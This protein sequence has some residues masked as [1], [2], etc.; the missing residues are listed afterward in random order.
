MN[1]KTNGG[2]RL[3]RSWVILLLALLA[4]LFVS[5]NDVRADIIVDDFSANQNISATA[6]P[7]GS[8]PPQFG[9]VQDAGILGGE[10]DSQITSL[11]GPAGGIAQIL[12]TGGLA[13]LSLPTSTSGVFDFLYDGVDPAG[14]L[15]PVSLLA[16]S[17]FVLGATSDPNSPV[18]ITVTVFDGINTGSF[19]QALPAA[20]GFTQL[21]FPFASF[22]GAPGPVNFGSVVSIA[23]N[24]QSPANAD[25]SLDNFVVPTQVPEPTSLLVMSACLVGGG[26]VWFRRKRAKASD[27]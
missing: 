11:S 12:V 22:S 9:S 20:G 8:D 19:S 14:T 5:V 16:G 18:Q 2:R 21:H 1:H 7:G 24:V 10:R 6:P 3:S 26:V 13:N 27:N 4:V 23:L 17:E 15:G 25:V